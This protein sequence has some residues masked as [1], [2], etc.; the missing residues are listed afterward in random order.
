MTAMYFF[1]GMLVILQLIIAYSAHVNRKS[2]TKTKYIFSY[3][4]L[5]IGIFLVP[6]SSI[7]SQWGQI[8]LASVGVT[9]ILTSLLVIPL[10]TIIFNS[11]SFERK[12]RSK[13]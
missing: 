12:A 9:M 10:I 8:L 1:G 5:C 2:N 4:Q 6:V 7:F 3:V 13:I 11:T